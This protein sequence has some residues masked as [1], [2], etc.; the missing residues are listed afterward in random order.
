MDLYVHQLGI[1][2]S[3]E[4][5]SN[6]V[7]AYYP[8]DFYMSAYVRDMVIRYLLLHNIPITVAGHGWDMFTAEHTPLLTYL[9]E[10][11][12]E[13]SLTLF[14]KSKISLNIMPGFTNGSHDRVYNSMLHKSVCCTDE[15]NFLKQ[16]FMQEKDILFYSLPSIQNGDKTLANLLSKYL[17]DSS[18]ETNL[19][20]LE[21][22]AENGYT[23]MLNQHMAVQQVR[24]LFVVE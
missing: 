1:S 5:F 11:T 15:T 23:H 18:I 7:H 19:L 4:Q 24:E 12:Y 20:K 9:G 13:N 21:C 17:M 14:A 8:V 2:L 16:E 6:F 10:F 22:I 3:K